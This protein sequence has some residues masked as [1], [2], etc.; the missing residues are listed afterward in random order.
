MHRTMLDDDSESVSEMDI[1]DSSSDDDKMELM[2][3]SFV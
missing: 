1:E 3:V 2:V